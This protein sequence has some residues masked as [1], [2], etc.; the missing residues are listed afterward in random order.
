MLQLRLSSFATFGKVGWLPTVQLA[1]QQK[2][3]RRPGAR[4]I[5]Q[6]GNQRNA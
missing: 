6:F 1:A 4:A 5:K 3:S 2:R